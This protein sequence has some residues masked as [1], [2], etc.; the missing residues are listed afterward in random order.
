MTKQELIEYG[1]KIPAGTTLDKKGNVLS[2][3]GNLLTSKNIGGYWI[4]WT[5]DEKGN[6]LTLRESSGLFI[7]YTKEGS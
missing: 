5:Y 6:V 7:D 4:E 2:Y 1:K 3:R